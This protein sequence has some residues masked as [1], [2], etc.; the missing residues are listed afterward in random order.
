[1][2][3]VEVSATDHDSLARRL[4]VPPFQRRTPRLLP[5]SVDPAQAD[6]HVVGVIRPSSD[7]GCPALEGS[8]S[9]PPSH[10]QSA[11]RRLNATWMMYTGHQTCR[12]GARISFNRTHRHTRPQRHV[13]GALWRIEALDNRGVRRPG[14]R[15]TS[16]SSAPAAGCW[17]R[18]RACS[19]RRS[20]R[21]A[22]ALRGNCGR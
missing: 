3:A 13:G 14:T 6:Q 17:Y 19:V 21:L 12:G 18:W 11:R 5:H 4:S 16:S 1:M 20:D 22:F 15:S 7:V 2:A 9:A 10:V 8:P